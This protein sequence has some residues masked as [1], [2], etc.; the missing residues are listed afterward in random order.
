MIDPS[1]FQGGPQ[2]GPQFRTPAPSSSPPVPQ[3]PSYVNHPQQ[4][5]I[6]G[7][8]IDKQ[9]TFLFK[10]SSSLDGQVYEGQFTCR[11]LSIR[12]LAQMGVRKVQLN[13]GYHFDD[14]NPGCGIE[15]HIDGM[16]SMIAHLEIALVQAPHWFRLDDVYDPQLLTEVYMKVV[17]FENSFFRRTG[18][19]VQ[20]GYSSQNASDAASQ[21]SNVVGSITPVGGSKIPSAM[22]P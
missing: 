20:P 13:G 5:G 11:K 1:Q 6:M 2:G 7:T 4:A 9:R 14:K 22:E 10:Y 15:E 8:P 19:Q 16:N 3:A 18:G 21:G 17:E 12:D